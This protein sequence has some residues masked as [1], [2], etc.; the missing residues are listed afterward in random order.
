[1][2]PVKQKIQKRKRTPKEVIRSNGVK[3]KH[4][5]SK[6]CWKSFE[7]LV[8]KFFGTK[9]VPLSGSNSGH[10]TNSDSMHDTLY[11]E[12]KVREKFALWSLFEDTESKAKNESKL[13]IVAIKQ[14]GSK[15]YLLVMRPEDLQ[16]IAEIQ[17]KVIAESE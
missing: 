4:P 6:T 2:S 9:R 13:P 16:K 5:T 17:A 12:C 8:A 3:V 1:M 11:I 15:G 10:N 7:R 14:K